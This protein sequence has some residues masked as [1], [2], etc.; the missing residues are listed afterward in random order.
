MDLISWFPKT[1][2]T[3][4][5]LP[6]FLYFIMCMERTFGIVKGR[7][8]VLW[9]VQNKKAT[10]LLRYLISFMNLRIDSFCCSATSVPNFDT[11]K[12]YLELAASDII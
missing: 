4:V 11:F 12:G 1:K 2:E 3:E 9:S 8:I 5:Y 10:S 6:F 7:V